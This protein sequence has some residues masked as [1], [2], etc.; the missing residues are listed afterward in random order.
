MHLEP[1]A[2]LPSSLAPSPPVTSI[3]YLL[4]WNSV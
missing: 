1:H 4:G 2:Q 3:P